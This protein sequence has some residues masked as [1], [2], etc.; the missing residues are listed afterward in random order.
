VSTVYLHSAR[1]LGHAEE[2]KTCPCLGE[3]K[4]TNFRQEENI[5]VA[6]P[7]QLSMAVD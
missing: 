5:V 7:G 6:K 1:S 2:E 3:T 4:P